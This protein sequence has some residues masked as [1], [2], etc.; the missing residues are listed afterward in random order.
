MIPGLDVAPMSPVGGQANVLATWP[1][2]HFHA[3]IGPSERGQF[4]FK[5]GA[6]HDG[7]PFGNRPEHSK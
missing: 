4:L 6:D 3:K 7:S 2:L 1:E 5:L